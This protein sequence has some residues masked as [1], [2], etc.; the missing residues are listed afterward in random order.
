MYLIALKI[1]KDYFVITIALIFLCFSL[2]LYITLTINGVMNLN[3]LTGSILATIPV[4]LG[5]YVGG[6]LRNKINQKKFE[7]FL[8]I[9]LI[10]I[11]INLIRRGIF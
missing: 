1:N 2:T 11:G 4:I 10:I 5:V 6:K 3:N 8:I 9:F 7:V